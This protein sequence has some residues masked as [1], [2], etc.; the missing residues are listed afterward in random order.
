[1]TKRGPLFTFPARI[2]VQETVDVDI[3]EKGKIFRQALDKFRQTFIG[4]KAVRATA[5]NEMIFDCGKINPV[6]II[7]STTNKDLWREQVRNI[8]MHLEMSQEGYNI[9]IDLAPAY[10]QQVV[11]SA[12]GARRQNIGFGVGVKADINN[13][14]PAEDFDKDMVATVLAFAEDYVPDEL[15][16]FLNSERP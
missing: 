6:Q 3:P 10:A 11:Q 14:R 13:Q 8:R 2:F 16:K 15:V 4:H 12:D 9:N 7:A 5:I 1:M